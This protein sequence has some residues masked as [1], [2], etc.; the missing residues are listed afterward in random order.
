MF[1]VDGVTWSIPC[2]VT[3]TAKIQA[4][5]ISGLLLDNSYFNDVQGTYM[6]YELAIG[7]TR[8]QMNQ[9][10]QLYEILTQPVDGH[11]FVFP[12]NGDTITLTARVEE[13]TDEYHDLGALGNYWYNAAFRII[14]NHPSKEMTLEA[15]ITRGLSPL[16]ETQS[17]AEGTIMQMTNGQWVE[18]TLTDADEVA[19]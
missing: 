8:H 1:T 12:Y 5:E 10:Y 2:K 15:V 16:P 17:V 4:S 19:Y 13:I 3:R 6:E 9:Y 7:A 11:S 14:A 18:L